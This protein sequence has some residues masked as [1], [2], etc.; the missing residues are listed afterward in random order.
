[1][2]IDLVKERNNNE[3]SKH[4]SFSRIVGIRAA[5]C[6]DRERR[7]IL[8]D[9]L[10]VKRCADKAS[11]AHGYAVAVPILIDSLIK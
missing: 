7:G 4:H 9:S 5:V 11:R 3:N 8:H 2:R 10:H 1:M 6:G